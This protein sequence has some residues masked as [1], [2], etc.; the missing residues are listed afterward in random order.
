VREPEEF[1]CPFCALDAEG[2]EYVD[3]FE[4]D[5]QLMCPRCSVES[6]LARWRSPFENL[7]VW[8]EREIG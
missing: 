4:D 3:W 1:K 6:P 8:D 7:A 2:I 5:G